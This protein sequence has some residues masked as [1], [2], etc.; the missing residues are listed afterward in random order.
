MIRLAV[1]LMPTFNSFLI[2]D[3]EPF[4]PILAGAQVTF[5]VRGHADE[6]KVRIYDDDTAQVSWQDMIEVTP[7]EWTASV[8]A[9]HAGLLF[10]RFE[11][12]DGDE[13]YWM[14]APA[15]NM[16]GDAIEYQ[17]SEYSIPDYQ[18]TVLESIDE[19]PDWYLTAKFYHIFVDRY[20]NGNTDGHI[21]QPKPN[22]FIYGRQTDVP[23]YIKDHKGEVVRW[24]FYGGNLKGITAKLDDIQRLGVNALYLSP[25]FESNS[26]HR[27]DTGDYF[28][29]D[30]VLGTENDLKE[31]VDQVHARDMHIIFD[32]VFN[33]VGQYSRYFNRDGRYPDKGAYQGPASPY[34]KWFDFTQFPDQYNSWW[35]VRDLPVINKNEPSYRNFI[36]GHPSSVI[37]Y[38]NTLGVDGWRLDVADELPD[39]FIEGIRRQ[40]TKDQIL[41]GE[42]W[43]DASN[44][45]AYEKRR[46]Y[47]LGGGLQ[48]TM[49]YP[50]RS[51]IIDFMMGEIDAKV[52]ANMMMTYQE[53]YPKTAFF[54]A[55][56]NVGTHDTW[57]ILSQ[58][59]DDR[60]KLKRA[61]Q[62]WISLPGVPSVYY[63]DEMGLQGE[64]DPD[65]RRYYPWDKEPDDIYREFQALLLH[66]PDWWQQADWFEI[67]AL[68]V[69][70]VIY[71]YHKGDQHQILQFN[72]QSGLVEEY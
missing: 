49:H 54:G 42:V 9:Q 1:T 41:I 63:G 12:A 52:F 70:T 11:V 65:N 47:L 20:N 38:W 48:A 45:V 15:N 35:G 19:V 72:R 50:L 14:A 21:N 58:L 57:R 39:D 31:L 24:D 29:V 7:D 3:K 30:P 60:E 8:T 64:K 46:K 2:A 56:T 68:N 36:Y 43:E 33:H 62:L 18:L 61:V 40:L 25:I 22:T 23:M 71:A 10:Y 27:Y 69:D 6:V 26:N 55:F 16:G 28:R 67:H 53:H 17:M 13:R 44:K 37:N 5:T 32:G 51:L 4:G 66:R 59:G 34:Y